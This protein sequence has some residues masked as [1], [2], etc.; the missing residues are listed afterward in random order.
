MR[1]NRIF[2]LS[3]KESEQINLNLENLLTK[4]EII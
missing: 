3:F 1:S 4:T 2:I